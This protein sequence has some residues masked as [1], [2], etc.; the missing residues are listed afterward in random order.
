MSTRRVSFV[1]LMVV[2]VSLLS[3]AQRYTVHDLG[4]LGGPISSPLAINS[5][6]QVSGV[7]TLADGTYCAFLW[8][9]NS[10]MMSLGALHSEDASYANGVNAE[11]QVVGWSYS[12]TTG[13]GAFLWT[14][15]DG[16]QDIGSLG[17]GGSVAWAINDSAQVVGQ[18]TLSDG[19]S[20]HAFL[21]TSATGMRDLGTLGGSYSYAYG[22]NNSGQ[23]VGLSYLA[24]NLSYRAFLWTETRGMQDLGTLDGT[25]SRAIAVNGLGEVLGTS[26]LAS[27]DIGTFLWSQTSGMHIVPGLNQFVSVAGLSNQDQIVGSWIPGSHSNGFIWTKLRGSQNLNSL[28]LPGQQRTIGATVINEKGQIAADGISRHALL[29][30]PTKQSSS[31]RSEP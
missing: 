11:A 4:T 1:L 26:E 19:I 31:Q 18:S 6:G 16:M 14:Q 29:L 23:V 2:V 30:T 22:I 24:G 27:G 21:W 17:G 28:I 9:P 13:S 7:S 3:S 10:G 12:F 8:S 5:K 25:N 15:T 20:T